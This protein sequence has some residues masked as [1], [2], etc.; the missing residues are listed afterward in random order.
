VKGVKSHSS[1]A[2]SSE[3]A[4]FGDSCLQANYTLLTKKSPITVAPS[5][6]KCRIKLAKRKIDT[7]VRLA[8]VCYEQNQMMP[9]I[10]ASDGVQRHVLQDE[11]RPI[12][13]RQPTACKIESPLSDEERGMRSAID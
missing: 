8:I 10:K 9:S 6:R 1:N 11:V 2:I 5:L 13:Q 3:V 7:I 12:W 4:W